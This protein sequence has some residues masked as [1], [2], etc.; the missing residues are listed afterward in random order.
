LCLALCDR[1]RIGYG[2]KFLEFLCIVDDV[3]E[4]LPF[5]EACM[6]HD[7]L[8]EALSD[9]YHKIDLDSDCA[10]PIHRAIDKMRT[11]LRNVRVDLLMQNDQS[12]LLLLETLDT[13][14]RN[15]DSVDAEFRNLEEYITYRK[16]NFDYEFV[17]QLLRWGTRTSLKLDQK[18]E[19]L[20]NKYEDI[21]GAIVGLTN[22]YF[23]W[24]MER[25]QPTDRL[26]NAVPVLMKEYGVKEQQ[27]KLMLKNAILDEEKRA[28]EMKEEILGI[29][30]EELKRYVTTLESFAAGYSFW[31]STCPRYSHPQKE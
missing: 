19:I 13:S 2:V 17:C 29:D 31:C 20:A 26:R 22:D 6:A 3:T 1:E 30:S 25:Q 8:R 10:T 9:G 27:A 23:S 11:F 18:E 5:Q 14:L 24:E 15:R 7:I 21:I 12:S 4:D 16:M 28:I